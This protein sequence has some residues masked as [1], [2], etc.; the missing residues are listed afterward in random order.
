MRPLLRTLCLLTLASLGTCTRATRRTTATV[1]RADVLE[2]RDASHD[3]V[4]V[5]DRGQPPPEIPATLARAVEAVRRDD[6]A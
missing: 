5:D 3:V 1:T 2:Q 6:R 4:V